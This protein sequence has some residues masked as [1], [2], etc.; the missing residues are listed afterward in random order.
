MAAGKS[1][2]KKQNSKSCQVEKY[3][4]PYCNTIKKAGDFYM[5][6]DPMIMTGKTTM[7]KDCA[8]KI[9]FALETVKNYGWRVLET[10]SYTDYERAALV[11][12]IDTLKRAVEQR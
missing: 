10:T 6:S 3:L 5:S 4:C 9:A 2:G 1:A 7:C 8:E 12:A 11:N